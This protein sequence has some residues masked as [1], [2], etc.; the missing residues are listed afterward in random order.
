MSTALGSAAVPA[1]AP[2]LE[3]R[4]VTARFGSVAALSRVSLTLRAGEVTCV[5]GENGS[6]KSTLVA[7]LSGLQRHDEGELLL[8]GQAVRF[9]TPGQARAAG[10]ATVWQDLAVAPVMSVWRN[11]FLGAE[12][13]RGVWPFR[14]LDLDA[15]RDT[16]VREMARIGVTGIDP[17]APASALRA[18]ER[19]SLAI[20]RAL[21]FGARAL[22]VDEP[23]APLT[24]AQHALVLESLVAARGRGLAVVFVTHNP[25]YAHLV[26]DHYVLMAHG[27]VA[28]N[29]TRDDVD[30]EDLTRLLAGGDDLRRLTETLRQLHPDLPR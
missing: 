6:G 10:I 5:L 17:D 1:V 2:L 22:V 9:R 21:H 29:L 20:A 24:V 3:L 25:Q 4:G 13:T 28:S 14:Q 11:F 12:P 23:T 16:T 30:V 27:Q 19:H 15:A 18:G 8:D 26:G 7:L